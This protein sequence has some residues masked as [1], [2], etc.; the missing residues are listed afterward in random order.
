VWA[1]QEWGWNTC[2]RCDGTGNVGFTPTFHPDRL[3]VPLH[4][5]KPRR[6]FV[7]SMSDTFHEAFTDEQISDV[8]AAMCRAPQHTYLLL[9]KR[10]ERMRSFFIDGLEPPPNWWLGVTVENQ[11][12]ADERI[13]L[14]LATP[15]AV[16]WVSC[17]PL[18]GAISFEDGWH[19]YLAG[20]ATDVHES[21]DEYG[22]V[23]LEPVPADTQ[24]LDW[25]VLSGET[26]P[27]ASPMEPVWAESVWEQCKAAGVPFF[28]KQ[29]SKGYAYD[30][31]MQDTRELPTVVG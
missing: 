23:V 14:L 30:A 26:G 5:R 15:A 2:P 12:R 16:H 10:P 9:T 7:N 22:E 31:R 1:G 18:L 19:D 25:V 20:R 3:D 27:G 17:E 21:R 6:V 4:W 8:F 24:A 28:W 13:P 29:G 11:A